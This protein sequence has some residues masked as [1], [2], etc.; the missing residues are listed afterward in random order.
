MS[1]NW[2]ITKIEDSDEYCWVDVEGAFDDDGEQQQRLA[3]LT[4]AIILSMMTVGIPEITEKN[5]EEYYTRVHAMESVNG[6]L[7]RHKNTE[8]GEVSDR[9]LTPE[10]IEKHIGLKTNACLYTKAKFWKHIGNMFESSTARTLKAYKEKTAD[11][12]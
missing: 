2:D 7:L 10:D 6:A 11:A 12:A 1:L 9:P 4:E 8:T 3:Y 5:W